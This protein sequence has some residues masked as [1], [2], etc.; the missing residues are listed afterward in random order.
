[1]NDKGVVDGNV[2]SDPNQFG[3]G[4][5][6][7]T[8]LGSPVGS[9]KGTRIHGVASRHGGNGDAKLTVVTLG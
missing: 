6:G 2:V 5:V 8:K 7:G 1:M 9:A 4:F 3:K